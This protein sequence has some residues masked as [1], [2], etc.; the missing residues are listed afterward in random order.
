MA[1]HRLRKTA[2]ATAI[3][4]VFL[5]PLCAQTQPA[6][7][8]ALTEVTVSAKAAPVLDTDRA[9][10]GG[11]GLP[12]SQTPQSITVLG[13]GGAGREDAH[14]LRLRRH[15]QI[16]LR[17]DG[18]SSRPAVVGAAFH[19][20]QFGGEAIHRLVV[21]HK[22]KTTYTRIFYPRNCRSIVIIPIRL[23]WMRL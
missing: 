16:V 12:L 14:D 1:I 11:F 6:K 5:S 10:V 20:D 9:D 8:A 7:P 22:T 4:L 17:R 21:E 2:V 18:K 19:R 23:H 13:A 15:R 3:G